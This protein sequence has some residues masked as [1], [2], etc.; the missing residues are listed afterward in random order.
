MAIG[1]ERRI[2]AFAV[3][4][5]PDIPPAGLQGDDVGAGMLTALVTA[6]CTMRIIPSTSD[7]VDV[8]VEVQF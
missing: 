3:V 1:L 4:A 5:D 8:H 2:E 7:R 6:S